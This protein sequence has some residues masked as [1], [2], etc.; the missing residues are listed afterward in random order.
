MNDFIFDDNE[1]VVNQGTPLDNDFMVG[2]IF[3]VE[4]KHDVSRLSFEES[5]E[6]TTPAPIFRSYTS[7][8]ADRGSINNILDGN[9]R[10]CSVNAYGSGM[11]EWWVYRSLDDRLWLVYKSTGTFAQNQ[12]TFIQITRVQLR[13]LFLGEQIEFDPELPQDIIHYPM[14]NVV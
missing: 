1:E 4:P 5:L 3:A 10:Q 2:D 14:M 6:F 13:N 7:I 11:S 8:E 12:A 9:L